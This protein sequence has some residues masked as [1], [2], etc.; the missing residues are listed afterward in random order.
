MFSHESW[1]SALG[2]RGSA[3]FPHGDEEA[4]P[5]LPF[6]PSPMEPPPA[7]LVLGAGGERCCQHG[8]SLRSG[9]QLLA[10]VPGKI[11]PGKTCVK[12]A[13]AA[14]WAVRLLNP[15]VRGMLPGAEPPGA[16]NTL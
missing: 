15:P 6:N 16:T 12:H 11:S 2:L 7:Q 14:A 1:K 10:A 3:V 8:P 4:L 13:A 9:C 5:R